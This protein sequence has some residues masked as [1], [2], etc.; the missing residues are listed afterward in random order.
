M[1]YILDT[2]VITA[3]LKGN[4]KAKQRAVAATLQNEQVLINAISYYEIKR[5]LLAADATTQLGRFVSLCRELGVVFL[6]SLSVF[7]IAAETY[8][9]LKRKGQLLEDADI[10]IGSVA[11]SHN[12]VLVSDD[13]DFNRIQG[14][15]VE[16]WLN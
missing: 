11:K 2:N 7:D 10:L 4:Q 13:S 16:N 1:T 14:L 12:W 3:I 6:D 5:G 15:T 8:A 9:N